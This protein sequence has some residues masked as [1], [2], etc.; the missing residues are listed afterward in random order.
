MGK[1]H[2]ILSLAAWLVGVAG[3]LWALIVCFAAGMKSVPRLS[4]GEAASTFPLPLLSILAGVLLLR[5]ASAREQKRRYRLTLVPVLVISSL[6][7]GL[8]F[9]TW[10]L[11]PQR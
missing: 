8:V 5:T 10:I 11:Q 1:S 4:Y 3:G 2:V 6:A 9:L 7:L